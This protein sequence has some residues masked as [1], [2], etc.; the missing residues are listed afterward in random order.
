MKRFGTV[1]ILSMAMALFACGG[2]GSNVVDVIQG[3]W[4]AGLLN[5]DGTSTL[6][7]TATMTQSGSTVSVTKFSFTAPSSCFA[8]GTTAT[9]VFDSTG[10]THGVTSGDF[11][12]TVQSGPSNANG[13]NVLALHGTFVG[14]AISGSWGLS[15]TGLDCNQP[16]NFTSGDFTMI[17]M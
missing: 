8:D 14:N 10:T 11:H 9:G 7:F 16:G 6:S 1:I 17:P 3:N 13:M 15:G 5:P 12:M 2:G 4:E